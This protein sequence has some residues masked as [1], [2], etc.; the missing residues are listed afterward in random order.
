MTIPIEAE[1]AFGKIQCFF[2]IK[3]KL[4]KLGVGAGPVAQWL[5][6]HVPLRW[7][8]VHRVGS[9]VWTW[10]HVACHA[11]VGIPCIK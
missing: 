9:Q 11:V 6:A 4:K 5:S 3:R 1:K 8:G 10:H 7:P 2:M